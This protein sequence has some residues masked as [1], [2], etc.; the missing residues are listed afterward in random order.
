MVDRTSVIGAVAEELDARAGRCLEEHGVIGAAVADR[1][2][3]TSTSAPRDASL[4]AG[5]TRHVPPASTTGQVSSL[6]TS[7]ELGVPRGVG[8]Y[9]RGLHAKHETPEEVAR[10][11]ADHGVRWAA[12]MA[13]GLGRRGDGRLIDSHQPIA[14]TAE[15][16]EALRAAG[17]EPWVWLFP[18]ASDPEGAAAH[19]GEH[20]RACSAAGAILDVESPYKGR[21]D[22]CRRLARAMRAELG[23]ELGLASTTYAVRQLHRTLPY[24]VLA[25]ET[26]QGQLQ[27]YEDVTPA[28]ARA[29][30]EDYRELGW[31]SVAAVGPAFG[32]RSGLELGAYLEA[33]YLDAGAAMVD[34]L[35]IWSW[36][37]L[38]RRE[39]PVL[40]RW[41]ARFS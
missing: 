17:V 14:R 26:D 13:I 15:Y 5:K 10:A 4:D 25:N 19:A 1:L 30:I 28:M 16:A 2:G 38:D 20:V 23:L 22:A 40:E 41:A 12:L 7:P 21:A 39:W 24:D 3:L 35:G 6:D 33:C 29:A 18:T 34:A 8:I 37:Q 27:A 9:L 31:R 36:P 32:R 11:C